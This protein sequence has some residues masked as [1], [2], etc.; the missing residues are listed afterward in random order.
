[1]PTA[2]GISEMSAPNSDVA[3]R[4]SGDLEAVQQRLDRSRHEQQRGGVDEP[5]ELLAL[6]P[7][8]APEARDERATAARIVTIATYPAPSTIAPQTAPAPSMPSGLSI[9][10]QV[11]ERSRVERRRRARRRAW[12]RRSATTSGRQRR[13]GQSPGGEQEEQQRGA[14]EQRRHPGQVGDQAGERAAGQR[15][16]SISARVP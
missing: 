2:I 4:Q 3:D 5:L 11:V 9:R 10:G 8:R 15:P 16:A 1:M 12:R 14:A 7:A 6:V 13:D